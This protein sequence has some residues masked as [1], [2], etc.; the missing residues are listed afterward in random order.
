MGTYP[1]F[2]FTP[3]DEAIVIWAAGKIWRVPL[4]VNELG[5]KVAGSAPEQIPFK[6]TIRKQMAETLRPKTNLVAAESREYHRLYAFSEPDINTRGSAV[7]VNAAGVNYIQSLG[8]D[9][10]PEAVPVLRREAA[11]YS[12]SFVQH[13][14]DLVIHARWHD[15]KFS[16]FEIAQLSTGN[17]VEISGL[18]L[19]RYYAPTLCG[20]KSNSRRLA[21]VRFGGTTATGSVVATAG[22]GLY[23]ADVQLPTDFSHTS[24]V[25][26]ENVRLV[27]SDIASGPL[28]LRFL[29]GASRLLVQRDSSATTINLSSEDAFGAYAQTSVASA[30]MSNELAVSDSHVAFVE[31][32]HVYLAPLSKLKSSDRAWAKP[33]N[34]T[35]GLARLSLDGGHDIIFSGDGKR[36]F[37]LLGARSH[38]YHLRTML[39]PRQV[40]IF[41]VSR[42]ANCNIVQAR[43]GLMSRPSAFHASRICLTCMSFTSSTRVRRRRLRQARSSS[44]TQLSSRWPLG[45]RSV[46]SFA[47]AY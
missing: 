2:S 19:G 31:N 22:A 42:S 36:L 9:I 32:Q 3:N 21:F 14:P 15:T 4:A 27:S 34:A 25:Q 16:T 35:N 17:A 24:S 33:G 26:V 12:P 18:P 23:I 20:C 1:S 13:R 6:A 10:R 47:K 28:K 44:R 38:Y 11:Y 43:F 41:I 40:P 39:I 7:L 46:M 45:R 8:N 37:W 30:R 5:E 29:D